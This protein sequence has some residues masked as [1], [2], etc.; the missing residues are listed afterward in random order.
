MYSSSSVTKT[1]STYSLSPVNA[2]CKLN[3]S[4]KL[5]GDV[6]QQ[7]YSTRRILRI[8]RVELDHV[9]DLAVRD[10]VNLQWLAANEP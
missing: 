4:F 5:I 6:L 8:A 2:S 3:I 9:L 10:L 7:I 1:Y